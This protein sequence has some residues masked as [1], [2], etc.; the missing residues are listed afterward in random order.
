MGAWI[1]DSK[2]VSLGKITD[3]PKTDTRDWTS[4]VVQKMV[5]VQDSRRGLLG[6]RICLLR[7]MYECKHVGGSVLTCSLW[8]DEGSCSQHSCPLVRC[9]VLYTTSN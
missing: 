8:P 5:F 3:T 9:S 7:G 6:I 1:L 4:P 2:A